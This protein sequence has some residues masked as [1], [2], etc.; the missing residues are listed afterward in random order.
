MIKHK[1]EMTKECPA[2]KPELK[3]RW[4][5]VHA[6]TGP[7]CFAGFMRTAG[8]GRRSTSDCERLSTEVQ[9]PARL[10]Q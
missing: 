5:A 2:T 10:R 1:E 4:I 6:E 7:K 8:L 9:L 3:R